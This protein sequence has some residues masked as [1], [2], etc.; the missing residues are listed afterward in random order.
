MNTVK[1]SW[2]TYCDT[3]CVSTKSRSGDRRSKLDEQDFGM[4]LALKKVKAST[5]LCKTNCQIILEKVFINQQYRELF[6][7]IN[8]RWM[9]SGSLNQN[10][11]RKNDTGK[12]KVH[13]RLLRY[14]YNGIIFP[15]LNPAK[16]F[17]FNSRSSSRSGR[18][19]NHTR[20]D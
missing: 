14:I 2:M 3:C 9:D 6:I 12:W 20:S 4:T 10:S 5:S 11:N 8:K 17:R 18:W 1:N 7:K 16:I 13:A 15:S 19:A